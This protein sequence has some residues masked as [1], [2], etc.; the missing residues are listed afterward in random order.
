MS[1][2]IKRSLMSIAVRIG[3]ARFM[4]SEKGKGVHLDMETTKAIA[5]AA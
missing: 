2:G 5:S 3:I 4:K 1:E